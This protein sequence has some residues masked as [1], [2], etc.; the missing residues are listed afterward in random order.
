VSKTYLAKDAKEGDPENKQ[1]KV[2]YR[3]DKSSDAQDEG[4]KV[5]HACHG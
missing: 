3:D 5:E 1:N 4:N 2:P